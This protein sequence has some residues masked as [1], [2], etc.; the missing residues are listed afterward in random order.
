MNAIW[1]FR[2]GLCSHRLHR[3]VSLVLSLPSFRISLSYSLCLSLPL[4]LY[5]TLS[6]S[7]LFLFVPLSLTHILQPIRSLSVSHCVLHSLFL[8]V[9]PPCLCLSL[10]SMC[11]LHPSHNGSSAFTLPFHLLCASPFFWLAITSLIRI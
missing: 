10:S 11:F 7:V 8:T 5:L 1:S 6:L 3:D 9:S 2:G 4:C